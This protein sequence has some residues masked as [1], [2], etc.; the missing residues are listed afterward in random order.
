MDNNEIEQFFRDTKTNIWQ[1]ASL[2]EPQIEGYFA[3]RKHFAESKEPCYVQLP[4]GCGKTGLMGLTPFAIAKGRVLIIAPNLTIRENIR[5]ELN[6]SNPNCFYSKR[7]VFV[8]KNGPYLSELKTGANIHDCDAA[9]IVVAN[10]QQFSGARNKWYEALPNDYFDMILVDE[11]HHNVAETWTRLFEYFAGTKVVSFTATPMRSDGQVVSGERVYRFGYARSMIMGFISQIDALFVKPT[12]LTFT[13]EGETKTL[14]I[15]EIMKMRDKD[16]FSRGVAT[17]EECNRSIV[18]ASV[19]QLHHVRTLG[20]PRQLIAVAC[21]IRHATQVAALYREHG[22]KVEVLHSQLKDEE[23]E[24]IE[25]T[26]RSG[27]TDVVVQVNI[28]G[29]GYDLPTLSVAAVFRPYRSL[30]PYVQFVGRILRLAQPDVPYSP[31]NHVY[32]VS[33]VGL[34]DERW[35]GDFT[36]FDKDDQEFFHEF[37]QGEL[38]VDG[39]GEHS[40]RMTLRPFMRVLNEVVESYHR[41]GYLKKI[42]DVMI[43]D[44]FAT[45][46]EKGFE[47]TEFGLSEEIVRN[48]LAAAQAESQVAAFNPVIQPQERRE[49]LKGRMQ[50][51]ARSIADT[52]MNRLSLQPRG[53]DLLRCFSGNFNAEIL[54]RLASA[55]Q[56]N[57]MGVESGQRQS[58]DISQLEGAINAS[59]DIADKLSSLVREKLKNGASKT[60]G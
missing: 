10:I 31:A 27:V 1:N 46:R 11:G 21:S 14:G 57:V 8:P 51:E 28:L 55:E 5:R 53:R 4:V 24:R 34:N 54:I 33:H 29:E 50:Q 22:L 43:G 25:A 49:A 19:Q 18:N 7:G 47:P 60:D 9:H 26:L 13:V 36:N 41:K 39:E 42:D 30:S 12:E 56:N 58:A 40:P 59:P 17:S 32:L 38:E 44:L 23:R 37:L 2:R 6:V 48:R 3:I 45:I 15:D 52:V 35:W 20:S 16:W